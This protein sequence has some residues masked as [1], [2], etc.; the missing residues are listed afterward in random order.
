MPM[1]TPSVMQRDHPVASTSRTWKSGQDR[2]TGRTPRPDCATGPGGRQWQPP[3]S[4]HSDPPREVGTGAGREGLPSGP[5][6][7]TTEPAA[8]RVVQPRSTQRPGS[9]MGPAL[10]SGLAG[11]PCQSSGQVCVHCVC[12]CTRIADECMYTRNHHGYPQQSHRPATRH[13]SHGATR[14]I[15]RVRSAD[16]VCGKGWS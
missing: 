9:W 8:E 14:W 16:A 7:A 3:A 12:S 11:A 10:H 13:V 1:T 4:Q 15:A 6:G 2:G 5:V